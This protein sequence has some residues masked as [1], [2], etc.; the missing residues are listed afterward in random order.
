MTYKTK[1]ASTV[2]DQ[3]V[4]AGVHVP[5]FCAAW[6]NLPAAVAV[7]VDKKTFTPTV[8]ATQSP[9]PNTQAL[10]GSP[11][12]VTVAQV[13]SYGPPTNPDTT[14]PDLT[15]VWTN[16]DFDLTLSVDG[17]GVLPEPV[18]EASDFELTQ[19]PGAGE[20]IDSSSTI[21]FILTSVSGEDPRDG[22][23]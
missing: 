1:D 5:D 12:Q 8:P 11:V 3:E 18:Y 20:S 22:T 14:M 4:T 13:P 21:V 10:K 17:T 7:E 15:S 16:S 6:R 9:L 2:M 23:R 19:S